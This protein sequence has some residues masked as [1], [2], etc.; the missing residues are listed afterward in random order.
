M[1]KP[2]ALHRW[3][4]RPFSPVPSWTLP[5]QPLKATL[6]PSRPFKKLLPS[7]VIPQQLVS[8]QHSTV[9]KCKASNL[10]AGQAA[11]G[12]KHGPASQ[13]HTSTPY[14]PNTTRPTSSTPTTSPSHMTGT[15]NGCMRP[16]RKSSGRQGHTL[17]HLADQHQGPVLRTTPVTTPGKARTSTTT[18][19]TYSRPSGNSV[20]GP[21][22]QATPKHPSRSQP[23][24][25]H[26]GRSRTS[27]AITPTPET[28]PKGNN[29]IHKLETAENNEHRLPNTAQRRHIASEQVGKAPPR[30]PR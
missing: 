20:S 2:R 16:S 10:P 7:P 1:I 17:R 23:V 25:P 9:W 12:P 8:D 3:K 14:A 24:A 6:H 21:T 26:H 27:H 13:R 22:P 19:M 5:P 30:Q 29:K 15:W 4:R 28:S 18:V 11:P